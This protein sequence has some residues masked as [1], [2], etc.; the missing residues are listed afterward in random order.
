MTTDF[1]QQLNNQSV[2]FKMETGFLQQTGKSIPM[3]PSAITTSHMTM[4]SQTNVDT[5]T[6]NLA[7]RPNICESNLILQQQQQQQQMCQSLW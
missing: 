7:N 6:L 3:S 1:E 5:A 4:T 2:V